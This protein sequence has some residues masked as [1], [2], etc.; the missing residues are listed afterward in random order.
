MMSTT[1]HF[2]DKLRGYGQWREQLGRAIEQYRTWLDRYQL[3]SDGVNEAI[4]SMLEGLRSDRIVLA[5]AAE[6][7][8][9]KT[10]LINALFFSD[11]GV[12]L[13]PSSPG[14]TTMCPTEIF[15]DTQAGSYIRLL[16]IESR[17]SDI[18]L[19]EYKQHPRS[20]MQIDLDCD[21]PVQMQ[22][23]FQELAATKHVSV[24]EAKRLGL[25]SED[26]HIPHGDEPDTVEVPCWRH[27]LI[28]FPHHLLKE[29][30]TILD[31]PGLNALGAEPEL[32][33]QMLPKAQAV[34]FVL[35]ADTGVTK[36]DLDMWRNHVRGS[37]QG[38]KRG[39]LAVV[40][41][42][43]DSMWGDLQ[44]E[45]TIEKSIRSQTESVSKILDVE[46]RAIFPMSAKQALL[47][48]VKGDQNLLEKSRLKSFEDYLA[49]SVVKERQSLLL[50][51]VAQGVGH[52]VEESTGALDAQILDAERQ[53][54]DLR[55]I[56]VN[57]K[58][59][60]TQLMA[61]TRDQQSGYLVGVDQFQASRRVFAVQA[62]LLVDSLAPEKV[63]EIIKRTRKQMAG[64]LTTVGMKT[65][66][67]LVLD[68]LRVVLLNAVA[69]CEET[70]K[71]VK[72]IYAKFQEEHGVAELKP[73]LL[74]LK[75][76]QAELEQVFDEGEAFRGSASSTLMEQSTVVVK[77]YTTTIARAR[78]LF[79][80]AHKDAIGWTTMALVPL[81]HQIKDHKRL[82]ESRLEV[83]RKVNETGASLDG[84]IASLAKALAQL[85]QQHAEL[86][87]IRRVLQS[88][89]PAAE[90]SANAEDYRPPKAAAK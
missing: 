46:S 13:L 26:V 22:E 24:A 10:E 62:K 27:A 9:G 36:S 57:N 47:A 34:I 38:N 33:L 5:F 74:S 84:E 90:N 73:P 29:G 2:K 58:T 25:Y 15:Y 6:F 28:S 3:N 43:I 66:M 65:A 88:E 40:L 20:W 14:R 77:L 48:K 12:R 44:G 76:Y 85:R 82:I 71:L 49:D 83:L 56:D 19:S 67:K 35:A 41:N 23:A 53:I 61:E 39:G 8:R 72:G 7:S 37:R 89:P 50:A 51:S 31:T 21:S 30:L 69:V 1:I 18:P 16:A 87:A 68:E 11:T 63:E 59:K 86:A 54:N 75:Q 64:S 80:Q 81:V 52:L 4:S 70:R 55:Q 45:E 17:L 78:E 42:K 79:E 32:T 60:M